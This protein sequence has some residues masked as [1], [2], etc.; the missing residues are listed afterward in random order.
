MPKVLRTERAELDLIEVLLYLRRRSPKAADRL[1]STIDRQCRLLAQFPE[2]GQSREEIAPGLRC[3][4]AETYLL[5]YRPIP[6]GIELVRVVHGSRDLTN[7][8]D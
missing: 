5:F 6:D 4:V 3:S 7:L 2:I 8:F 1:E